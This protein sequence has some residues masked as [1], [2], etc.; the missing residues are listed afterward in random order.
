MKSFS[1]IQ[2]LL[3]PFCE[4]SI[5][6]SFTIRTKVRVGEHTKSN[7]GSDC[8]SKNS[9]KCNVDI[10]D[11]DVDKIILHPSYNVPHHHRNDIAV[12]KLKTAINENGN[13]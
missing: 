11:I 8:G 13:C 2:I 3:K 7:T 4:V 10:Q 5:L 12:I 6:V 1:S 9:L